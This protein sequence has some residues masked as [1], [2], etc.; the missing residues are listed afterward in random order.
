[1]S[2]ERAADLALLKRFTP[3]DG[4]KK[5]NQAAL[6]RKV[7]VRQMAANRLLFKEG[8]S[9]RRT[10]WVVSGTVELREGD[11]TIAM[12]RGGSPESRNPLAPQL[13]R[14]VSARAVDQVEYLSIDSE[15]LDVM[16][17][18]DQ[19]GTY[20]VTDLQ[21]QFDGEGSE[22]WMTTLLQNQAMHRIPPA[23]I[24]AIFMR[25]QRVSYRAGETV[26]QQGAEGDFFYAI[27]SGR[28]VVTRETPLNKDGIKLAELGVGDTFG[29]EALISES[30]RNATVAMLTEGVLM[31]LNKSDFRELMNEPLL[32][33]VNYEKARAMVADG[34]K[35]LDVRLPSEHQNL[36][37]EGSTNIPLY[38][39][40]LKL[41]TLDKKTRYVVY[42]DTGRRSSAAAFIL[43][44]R[45]FDA[46][47]LKDGLASVDT[48][49]RRATPA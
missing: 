18:W 44:E 47:V 24:Q 5:E 35:W 21:T 16:I 8:D 32:Q 26:I 39:I 28:C 45:G 46:Y 6:A 11:H 40:R 27:V 12:I 49:L 25:M 15:L 1:M 17:T 4:M 33:W 43:L 34:G 29:E 41:S 37:I 48:G 30:K 42:C 3:L 9:D 13:P 36:A 2:E 7:T 31:R 22:D 20:E 38:F 14:R 23:N 10:V 19:T